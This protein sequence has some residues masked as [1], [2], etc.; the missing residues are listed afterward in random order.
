MSRAPLHWSAPSIDIYP[1]LNAV[2]VW[3][4]RLDQ[5]TARVREL[6]GTLAPDERAR[7]ARFRFDRDRVHF[8]VGRGLLRHILARYLGS[9]PALIQFAY[10]AQGKPS[11]ATMPAECSVHFNLSHSQGLAIC[12]VATGRRVGVDVEY[13]RPLPDLDNI[14]Q[15]FFAPSEAA[16]LCHLPAPAR[17]A[18]FYRCWT[19]KEACIKAWGGGLTIPLDRFVVSIQD[20]SADQ[21]LEIAISDDPLEASHWSMRAFTPAPGYIAAVVAEGHGWHLQYFDADLPG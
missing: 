10:G 1:A 4:G 20:H 9:E 2:H 8:I 6:M 15:R 12:A 17:P 18:A 5:P 13:P 3:R 21:P 16:Q 7:A 19:R 14:A 11:L